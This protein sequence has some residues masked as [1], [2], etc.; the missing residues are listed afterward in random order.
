MEQETDRINAWTAAGSPDT[1]LRVAVPSVLV[2]VASERGHDLQRL[3]PSLLWG[4]YMMTEFGGPDA[5]DEQ[6]RG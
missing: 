2:E 6:D 1:D 4:H 5:T 3:I